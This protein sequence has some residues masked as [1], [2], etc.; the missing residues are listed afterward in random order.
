[1]SRFTLALQRSFSSRTLLKIMALGGAV[2]LLG[3]SCWKG[4]G[5]NTNVGVS[6]ENTNSTIQNS[7]QNSKAEVNT[8]TADTNT[9]ITNISNQTTNSSDQIDTSDWLTYTNEEYGFSFKYPNSLEISSDLNETG[10]LFALN[11]ANKEKDPVMGRG[12]SIIFIGVPSDIETIESEISSYVGVEKQN[13]QINSQPAIQYTFYQGMEE[14]AIKP[15]NTKRIF[16]Q[17][18]NRTIYITQANFNIKD[19]YD[20]WFNGITGTL[21]FF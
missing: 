21:N 10:Y 1:M 5:T 2:A 20:N 19:E 12:S 11:V 6:N 15:H 13:I 8:N 3:A 14:D 16:V 4:V 18:N 7:N 9:V 17:H